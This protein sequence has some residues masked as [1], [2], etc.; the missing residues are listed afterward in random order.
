LVG[1][2]GKVLPSLAGVRCIRDW[3][4]LR[5]RL[6]A[7]KTILCLGNGPSSE[8]AGI[9]DVTFDCL[10]RVNWIWQD[11]ALAN[12]D[13]VFTADL[14]PPSPAA[15][16]ICFPTRADANRILLGY[17]RR[18]IAQRVEY[19]VFP[20]LASALVGRAWPHRPTNGALMLAAAVALQPKRLVVAGVDLYQHPDGKYPGPTREANDYDPIHHRHT[21]LAFIRATLDGFAGQVEILSP[22]LASGLQR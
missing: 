3:D 15:A 8:A 11:R 13:V 2:L 7:P 6:G 1:S 14:D 17:W 21:D 4:A 22:Q 9:R 5:R 12:P 19:L 18:R 16:I 10:F 20:E